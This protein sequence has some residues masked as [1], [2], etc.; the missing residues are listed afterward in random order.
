MPGDMQLTV[1]PR[2]AHSAPSVCVIFTTAALLALY[3]ICSKFNHLTII[4]SVQARVRHITSCW[5][6]PTPRGLEKF[7]TNGD[8][9]LAPP[10]CNVLKGSSFTSTHVRIG[11]AL[12]G[13]PQLAT[14]LLGVS[15]ARPNRALLLQPYCRFA[16]TLLCEIV[17]T[18][19][20]GCGTS[21]LAMLA[22]FIMRPR[23]RASMCRPSACAQYFISQSAAFLGCRVKQT[24][25]AAKFHVRSQNGLIQK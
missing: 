10:A 17:K 12:Q 4:A 7:N 19:F 18:C 16:W 24:L 20:C 6:Y 1:R 8:N 21:R 5:T 9:R 23:P 3:A 2:P 15:S 13:V 14:W 25:N 22:V 11:H